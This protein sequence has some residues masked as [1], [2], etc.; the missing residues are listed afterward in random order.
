MSKEQTGYIVRN[1]E[2]YPPSQMFNMARQYF[3]TLSQG[4]LVKVV[5]LTSMKGWEKNSLG[6]NT[7]ITLMV[8]DKKKKVELF[9]PV[10]YKM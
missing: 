6:N 5:K 2:F 10:F 1:N 3:I 8:S 9:V 4:H 7:M